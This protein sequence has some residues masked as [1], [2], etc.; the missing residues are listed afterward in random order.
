MP[1]YAVSTVAQPLVSLKTSDGNMQ[2]ANGFIVLDLSGFNPNQP[3]GSWQKDSIYWQIA[4]ETENWKR[5]VTPSLLVFPMTADVYENV[6]TNRIGWGIDDWAIDQPDPLDIGD[7]N[8]VSVR[9]TLVLKTL[10]SEILR[11]GYQLIA[12]SS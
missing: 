11:V 9:A 4:V 1:V 7:T 2:I 12:V 8:I 6:D 5:P 10:T 3:S